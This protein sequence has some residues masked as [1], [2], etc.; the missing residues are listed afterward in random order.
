MF[1][2][3][4]FLAILGIVNLSGNLYLLK[5]LSPHYAI[6]IL[7]SPNNHLGFYSWRSIFINN[8]SRSFVL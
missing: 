8:W 6:K 1:I 2:W 7:F 5:A 3:F 4:A